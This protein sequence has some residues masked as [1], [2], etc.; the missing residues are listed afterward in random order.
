[1]LQ[2]DVVWPGILAS[3][4]ID[5]RPYM[6]DDTAGHFS[7]LMQNN[8]VDGRLVAIPWWIGTGVLY[9]RKDLLEKYHAKPPTTWKELTATARRIQRAER[10]AGHTGLWGYVWQ[11]RAYE[12]LT[13][14][15]L[16]WIDSFNGGHFVGDDG[17]VTVDNPRAIEALSLAASWVGTISPRGVLNYDEEAARGVFQTGNAIFMRNWPYAWELAQST[18]SSVRGKIGIT[19]LPLG[20]TAGKHSGALGGWNLAV[21]RYSKHP[22]IAAQL[23]RFLTSAAEQKWRALRGGYTPTRMALYADPQV[24]ARNPLFAKLFDAFQ[25][26]VARPSR[27]TG[28]RYSHVSYD[29]ARAV[30]GI[31]VHSVTP[32][33]G[34]ARLRDELQGLR[35]RT[36]W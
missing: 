14:N 31:L 9:Y 17:S 6:G 3:H 13:C 1:V 18:T 16:E 36:R 5:M 32:A 28:A 12:G 23:V 24:L 20:D 33:A 26:A 2:V 4:L 22:A 21:S 10:L 35:H 27:V 25:H 15:A 11:G 30:H 19:T 7:A 8:A 34:V 29:V